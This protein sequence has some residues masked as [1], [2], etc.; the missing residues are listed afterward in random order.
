MGET[1]AVMA[2]TFINGILFIVAPS[3]RKAKPKT[4]AS[5]RSFS[6]LDLYVVS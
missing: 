2:R 5:F 4:L 6:L 3:P 1:V